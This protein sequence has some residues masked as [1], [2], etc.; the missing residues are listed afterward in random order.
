[1]KILI[2]PD[3]FK[4][5]FTSTEIA[6]LIKKNLLKKKVD[7]IITIPISDGG[8]GF[9]DCIEI[10]YSTK[11]VSVISV[12]PLFQEI[13]SYFL[14]NENIAYI[15]SAKTCGVDLLKQNEQNPMYTSSYGLG[16]QIKSALKAGVDKII[17]GLGGSATNDAGIGMAAAFGFKFIDSNKNELLPIGENLSKIVQIVEPKDV[18]RYK[19][20]EFI[21]MTDVNHR[22][23]GINGAAYSFAKQKG[24]KE[25][26]VVTLDKG[27]RHF[28]NV[29]EKKDF[30]RLKNQKHYG[31][32]GGL[33]FG[34]KYFLNAKLL[35]G[36]DF[37]LKI[38]NI[39]KFIKDSDLIITGEG[40]LD[41]ESFK[42]KIVG[43]IAKLAKK[44]DK[45]CLIIAGFVE[46]IQNSKNIYIKSLFEQKVSLTIAKNE[47]ENRIMNLDLFSLLSDKK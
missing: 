9:L 1:M 18:N 39:D 4:S 27:L 46:Q 19:N 6:L 5:T 37:L 29:A 31:A 21:G 17:I 44:Y 34:L 11:K 26:E 32:A 41:E 3:K 40:K 33:G 38:M 7:D 28:Y 47:T 24:A 10:V 22:L 15:E 42:G 23:F 30:L 36:S 12:N 43:E 13:N 25:T 2:I 20:V 16:I 35:S 45:K 14:I 8:Q